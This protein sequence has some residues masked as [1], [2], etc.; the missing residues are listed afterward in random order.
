M[1]AA[2]YDYQATLDPIPGEDGYELPGWEYQGSAVENHGGGPV[3]V[4]RWRRNRL[5]P[6]SVIANA[7]PTPDL[8]LPPLNPLRSALAKVA[9]GFPLES[10]PVLSLPSGTLETNL[11]S[12]D[13]I[14]H[15]DLVSAYPAR[16]SIS[17]PKRRKSIQVGEESIAPVVVSS[18]QRPKRRKQIPE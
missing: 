18:I 10:V 17:R 3:R 15:Y 8:G 14:L 7:D 2:L 4:T 9:L 6:G 13:Q 1:T 16:E 12:G 11:S 5:P